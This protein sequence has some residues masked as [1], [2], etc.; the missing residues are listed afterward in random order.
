M[1]TAAGGSDFLSKPR[2]VVIVQ[3]DEHETADSV[4]VCA[5]S[6]NLNFVKDYRVVLDPSELNGL[7]VPSIVMGDIV[8]TVRR[9]RLGRPLI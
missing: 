6:S 3:S 9:T 2:P 1:W 4:T 7:L 5:L 8:T